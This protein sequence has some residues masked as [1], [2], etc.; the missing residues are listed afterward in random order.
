MEVA[1]QTINVP[2]DLTFEQGW[3]L[4]RMIERPDVTKLVISGEHWRFTIEGAIQ[5]SVPES[6]ITELAVAGLICAQFSAYGN[7]IGWRPTARARDFIADYVSIRE[8]TAA[9]FPD[10]V[11]STELI[12]PDTSHLERIANALEDIA[13]GVLAIDAKLG[14]FIAD[15]DGK[16]PWQSDAMAGHHE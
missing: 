2:E 11:L 15:V 5:D 6:D 14:R 16:D 7:F 12:T 9:E 8:S 13:A 3:L 4:A 1:S 10:Y